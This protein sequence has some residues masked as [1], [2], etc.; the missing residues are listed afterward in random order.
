MNWIRGITL[1]GTLN[2]LSSA[3]AQEATEA[4]KMS[5]PGGSEPSSI[6]VPL[7]GPAVGNGDQSEAAAVIPGAATPEAAYQE[8]QVRR[9]NKDLL[10]KKAFDEAEDLYRQG[11]FKAA[12][13]KYDEVLRNVPNRPASDVLQ[14]TAQKKSGLA[15]MKLAENEYERDNLAEARRFA[16][17]AKVS[18]PDLSSQADKL[19]SRASRR[20]ELV[21]K[22]EAVPV[23]PEDQP[24][25]IEKQMDISRLFDEG[26]QWFAVEEYDKAE[27]QFELILI[28]DPYHRDAMRFL[29][30]IEERRL[31]ARNTHREATIVGMTDEVRRRWTPPIHKVVAKTDERVENAPIAT[32]TSQRKLMDKMTAIVIPSLEFRQAYI[33]DVINFLREASIAADPD[34]NGVNLLLKLPAGSAASAPSAT[35]DAS[36]PWGIPSTDG[37]GGESVSA[38]TSVPLITLNLRKVTL[39]AAIKYVAEVANLKYRI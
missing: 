35:P 32:E 28:K 33:V 26:R 8:E 37:T 36:D 2:V 31:Q 30:K 19:I 25:V 27:A 15:R 7:T 39:L 21:K 16:E 38:S 4:D 9:Q 13:D 22:R 23:R 11:Q 34:G 1:I 12:A 17:E 20:E 14:L 6:S 18:N 29:R 24:A 10:A 3:F 5:S